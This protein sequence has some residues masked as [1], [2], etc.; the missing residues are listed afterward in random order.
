MKEIKSEKDY[1]KALK[2]VESLMDI[3]KYSKSGKRLNL[4]VK[5]ITKYE[6]ER[7]RDWK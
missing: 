1:E 2:E 6:S 5:M 3:K 7:F 4:L